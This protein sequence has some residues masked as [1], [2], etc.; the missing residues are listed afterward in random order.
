MR[1]IQIFQIIS[2]QI[3]DP[4]NSDC[5]S[6]IY[7]NTYFFETTWQYELKGKLNIHFCTKAIEATSEEVD[8]L[9]DPLLILKLKN[10]SNLSDW[11]GFVKVV[12]SNKILE[13]TRI[14]CLPFIKSITLNTIY[15]S[16]KETEQKCMKQH[17]KS[18]LVTLEQSLYMK[19]RSIDAFPEAHS[20]L[21]SFYNKTGWLNFLQIWRLL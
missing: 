20:D 21:S 19:T 16:L 11:D 12:T 6:E 4:K 13:T 14:L 2:I 3:I 7:Y 8:K 1:G 10:V 15:T 17:Q 18:C 9:A 5:Q